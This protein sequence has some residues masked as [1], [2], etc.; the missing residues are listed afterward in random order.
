[1]FSF[2]EV[3]E[4]SIRVVKERPDGSDYTNFDTI[5]STRECLLNVDYIVSVHPY[6]FTSSIDI[7]RIEGRFPEGS[8]FCSLVLDGH[9]FR[10]SEM[11]VVGSFEKFC[12]LFQKN[13]S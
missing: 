13:K 1:M 10:T 11:I 6:E 2:T 4:K 3:H 8:K 12:R 5:F 9:S 7:G